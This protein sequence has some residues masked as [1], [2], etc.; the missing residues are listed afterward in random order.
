MQKG[1]KRRLFDSNIFK[2]NR[3]DYSKYR[4]LPINWSIPPITKEDL[5]EE[6][7]PQAVKTVDMFRRKTIDLDHECM[8][9]FDYI[10]GNIVSCN[11]SDGKTP[12]EVKGIIYPYLLKKM[13]IAS[14]HNHPI[15]YCSPPSGK[16]F[17]ML[18]LEFE[19][20]EIISSKNELWILESRE[21]VLDEKTIDALRE[22]F[23][24]ALDYYFDE[25]MIEFEEGYLIL[26]A[27]NESYGD[28]LLNYLNKKCDKIKL[29][30]RYLDEWI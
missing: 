10:S 3:H 28:F 21:V 4:H 26:D 5:P 19:E 7:S 18:G 1:Q 30:R 14:V 2:S 8:I 15:Q 9:Y 11:F 16:N 27:V 17:E 6:F 24:D 12:N 25:M 23:D 20:F 29:T 22:K 13:H